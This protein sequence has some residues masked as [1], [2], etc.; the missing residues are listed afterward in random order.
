VPPTEKKPS[1][2]P[3]LSS[4]EFTSWLFLILKLKYYASA[5]TII[6]HSQKALNNLPEL[7]LS[8]FT[9]VGAIFCFGILETSQKG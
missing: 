3:C 1:F 6:L 7:Q 4:F 8:C 9:A 5:Y 2:R